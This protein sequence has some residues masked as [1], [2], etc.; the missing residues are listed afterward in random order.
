MTIKHFHSGEL[1]LQEQCGVRKSMEEM[2]QRV[3]HDFIPE[4]QRDFFHD[5]EYVLL[6]TVD[7]HGAPHAS[8]VTGTVGFIQ[9]PQPD[10]IVISTGSRKQRLAFEALDLGQSVGVL[11][12]DLSNRRRNRVHGRITAIDENTITL[13]VVQ[14]YG[15]CPKYISPREII[16][17]QNPPSYQNVS[18]RCS[19]SPQDRAT[20]SAADTFFIASYVRDNSGEPYEGVDVSHRGGRP[21]FISIGAD[22]S[23][24]QLT[25]P[26]YKGNNLFNTFG[27]LLVNP[28]AG[29]LF[30]NFETGDQLHIHGESV[31]IEDAQQV[32][33]F[34]E[35]LRLLS[36]NI[37]QIRSQAAATALRWRT[38]DTPQLPPVTMAERPV[39]F[40][41]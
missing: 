24:S 34:P 41:A 32:A 36:I 11:G 15:N 7:S 18:V 13:R 8:M 29:L 16:G 10:V 30:I 4:R 22:S 33:R 26:D 3:M 37:K 23:G 27:N 5:L 14:F 28:Q 6:G 40:F 12:I 31:L 38:L 9:T 39:Q 19:L 2:A 1:H 17:R 35:A 21:G 20:I 25:I